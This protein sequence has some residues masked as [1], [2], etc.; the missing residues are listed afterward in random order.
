MY[1]TWSDLLVEIPEATAIEALDDTGTATTADEVVDAFEALR[2]AASED[3]DAYLE[4]RYSVPLTGSIPAI[5]KRGALLHALQALFTKR[6]APERFTKTK[7]LEASI[8]TLE[9]IRDGKSQLTPGRK[10]TKPRGYL[11]QEPSR[12]W[13]S[14]RLGS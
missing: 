10:S 2:T 6:G 14:G 7:Q 13:G 12:T 1:F 4:G 9:K 11:S 8:R 3:V 5:V